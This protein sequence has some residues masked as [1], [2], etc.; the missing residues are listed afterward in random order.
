MNG[1]IK[2]N[3]LRTAAHQ[4]TCA[5]RPPRF[6]FRDSL[7]HLST[8]NS[9]PFWLVTCHWSQILSNQVF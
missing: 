3:I 2:A 1:M 7:C 8:I 6:G 5:F 4:V 9:Q